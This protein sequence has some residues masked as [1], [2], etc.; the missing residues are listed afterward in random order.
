[1]KLNLRN[2]A[3]FIGSKQ[4]NEKGSQTPRDRELSG[5]PFAYTAGELSQCSARLLVRQ[6]FSCPASLAARS[7]TVLPREISL[8]VSANCPQQID[9]GKSFHKLRANDAARMTGSQG[10]W[11]S[12]SRA[13]RC[14]AHVNALT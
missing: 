6:A 3:D 12:L 4:G 7:I 1:M 9:V 2:R 11:I 13:I 14:S 10:V 8:T 5:G